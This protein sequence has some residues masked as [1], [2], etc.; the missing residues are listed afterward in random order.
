MKKFKL[1]DAEIIEMLKNGT[2][3]IDESSEDYYKF[4]AWKNKGKEKKYV[5]FYIYLK[6]PYGWGT[7][8]NEEQARQF[9]RHIG[10]IAEHTGFYIQ[11]GSG[12]GECE[13]LFNPNDIMEEIYCHPMELSG[14]LAIE[15]VE[16]F[17]EACKL[18]LKEPYGYNFTRTFGE[19]K[20]YCCEEEVI[21]DLVKN[22]ED[23]LKERKGKSP[24]VAMNEKTKFVPVKEYNFIARTKD[25]FSG[26]EQAVVQFLEESNYRLGMCKDLPREDL[27]NDRDFAANLVD[28]QQMIM[29]YIKGKSLNEIKNSAEEVRKLLG[30]KEEKH[31]RTLNYIRRFCIE[32]YYRQ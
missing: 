31:P 15:N 12:Y 25:F 6:T 7:G 32:C 16:K 2:L 1:D 11:S 22:E 9:R 13:K 8:Y 18:L 28:N 10:E 17:E 5:R 14:T 27:L 19:V 3:K 24:W 20:P 4:L 29:D 26:L 23:I 30:W 21:A